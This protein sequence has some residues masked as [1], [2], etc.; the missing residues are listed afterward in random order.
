[1][2]IKNL[3]IVTFV[4][5]AFTKIQSQVTFRPGI[6]AGV[7]ISKL[8]ATDLDSKTDFYIGAFGALKLG[9]VYTLQPELT[10]SRQGGKGTANMGTTSTYNPATNSY[11]TTYDSGTVDAS[12]QY[13]SALTIN[14][15]NF[16]ES[17]YA[18]AGPFADILIADDIKVNPK[19][20]EHSFNKGDDIDLG[21]IAGLGY[22]LKNGIAFEAR[23]KKGFTN[24]FTNYYDESSDSNNLVFQFGATYTFGKK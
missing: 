7:N 13:I 21:I 14:K 10:Y 4:F 23:V 15:F 24:A 1:M 12:L 19:T 16:T 3:A 9:R 17:F 2:N 18:L 8:T 11:I 5:F 20:K 22:S 6:Q